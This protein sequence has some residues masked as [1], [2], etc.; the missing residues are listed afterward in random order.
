MY[1][2]EWIPDPTPPQ[3]VSHRVVYQQRESSSRGKML[4]KRDAPNIVP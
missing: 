2:Y 1:F 3:D 4:L